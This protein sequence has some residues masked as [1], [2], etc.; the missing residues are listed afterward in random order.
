MKKYTA[1]DVANYFVKYSESVTDEFGVEKLSVTKL[2]ILLYYAQSCE[3]AMHGK[4]L[5]SD[6]IYTWDYGVIID[7]VYKE[8]VPLDN[9]GIILDHDV[10]ISM[11]SKED[12]DMLVQLYRQF[13]QYSEWKLVEM[14][15]HDYAYCIADD[16]N[17]GVIPH[18]AMKDSF[19]E[20][21]A[22]EYLESRWPSPEGEF[23]C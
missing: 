17:S 15:E 12:R 4:P 6:V 10:D 22:D 2:Q 11:I 8:F 21:Y 9:H 18:E 23:L 3:L 20:K 13:G 19:L 7:K 1:V 14:V 5:F 16:Y